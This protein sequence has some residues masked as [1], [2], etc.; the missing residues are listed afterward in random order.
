MSLTEGSHCCE[1]AQ[2][3]GHHTYLRIVLVAERVEEV[4]YAMD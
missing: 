1:V 3:T 4:A 2:S